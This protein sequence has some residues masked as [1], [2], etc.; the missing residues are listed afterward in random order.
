[1]V[2]YNEF[3]AKK[4]AW[5]RE[6]IARGLIAKGEVDER[7]I[8]DV[9]PGDLRG[10]RQWHLFAGVGIWSLALRNAGW[11]DA[12]QVLTV[13]CPCTPF[14]TAG[15]RLGEKDERHLWPDAFRIIRDLEPPHVFGEQVSSPDGL[16]WYDGV[17]RDLN[18]CKYAVVASDLPACAFGAPHI[19]QRLY[20]GGIHAKAQK[21]L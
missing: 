7:T 21:K 12:R 3:D 19:R 20:F 11:V 10:Y 16:A 5:L 2:Y 13:S 6:L 14:S 8:R 18:S 17:K 4:A 1:M 9:Q 15:K